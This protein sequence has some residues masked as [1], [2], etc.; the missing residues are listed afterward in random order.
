ML[1]PAIAKGGF[2]AIAVGVT[3]SLLGC[4]TSVPETSTSQVIA[5]PISIVG[6]TD[7]VPAQP[8]VEGTGDGQSSATGDGRRPVGDHRIPATVVSIGDGDTLRVRS[9]DG[10]RITTRLGCVDSPERLQEGGKEATQQLKEFLPVEGNVTLRPIDRDRY[11]RLVAEVYRDSKSVNL[12][13]VERGSA[14]VYRQYLDGCAASRDQYLQAEAKAKEQRLGFWG[15]NDPVMPWE[16]RRGRR[17]SEAT[18]PAPV[19][20]APSKNAAPAKDNYN[21]SDFSTQAEAQAILDQTPGSDPHGLDR[22]G[23]RVACES[24]P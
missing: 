10:E 16:Y 24:L 15:Q 2:A 6:K 19:A 4:S 9:A 7:P 5:T 21:C 17:N 14:V 1:N 20:P 12:A 11:G 8:Q 23:D 18:A 22:D 3:I 13:M